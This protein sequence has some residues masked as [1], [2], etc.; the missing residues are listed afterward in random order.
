MTISVNLTGTQYNVGRAKRTGERGCVMIR[1]MAVY[2]NASL[3]AT[4]LEFDVD[5]V[6]SVQK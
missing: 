3:E 6:R 5:S 2:Q 1:N 4:L